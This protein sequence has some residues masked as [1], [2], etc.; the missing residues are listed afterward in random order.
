MSLMVNPFANA[1]DR[2]WNDISIDLAQY[3]GETVD[4]IFNTRSGTK[5][6]R[7]GDFAVWGEP[8]IVVK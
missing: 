8:R 2:K 3:A 7:N 1:S 4:V 6:D 5:D